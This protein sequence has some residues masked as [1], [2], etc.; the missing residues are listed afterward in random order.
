M[1]GYVGRHADGDAVSAIDQQVRIFSGKDR[2]L[3]L[4]LVIVLGEINS[5][6][7]DVTKQ[8]FRRPCQPGFGVAHRRRR[9]AV[10]RAEIALPVDKW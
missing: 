1:W 3:E 10:N 6:L 8:A 2:R 9:I 4:G 5:F 7:V